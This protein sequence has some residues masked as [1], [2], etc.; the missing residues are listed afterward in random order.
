MYYDSLQQPSNHLTHRSTFSH[1]FNERP[2]V[3]GADPL[4]AWSFKEIINLPYTAKHDIYGRLYNY[5]Q[6]LLVTFCER[7]RDLKTEF[8]IDYCETADLSER[9]KDYGFETG[10]F[11]RIDVR[12]T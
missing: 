10:S 12:Q 2:V 9:I 1:G 7:L 5:L 6:E 3:E 4:R 11:D 8:Y